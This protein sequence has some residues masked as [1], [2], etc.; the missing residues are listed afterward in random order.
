MRTYVARAFLPAAAALISAPA[1]FAQEVQESGLAAPNATIKDLK[2][3]RVAVRMADGALVVADEKLERLV[4]ADFGSGSF[5]ELIKQG[6]GDGEFGGARQIWRWTGDS[7]ALFDSTRNRVIVVS[8]SGGTPRVLTLG[9]PRGGGMRGGGAAAAGRGNAGMAG[10]GRG[11][12]GGGAGRPGG[13]NI[14]AVLEGK[15]AFVLGNPAPANVKPGSAPPRNMLPIIRIPLTPQGGAVDTVA[16]VMPAQPNKGSIRYPNNSSGSSA[17]V[18][19]TL[20]ISEFMWSDSWWVY[21]DGSVGVARGVD[22]HI[23]VF[24]PGDARS[25]FDPIPFPKVAISN[26]EK[27]RTSDD[28]KRLTQR[29][30]DRGWALVVNDGWPWPEHHPPFRHREK[31][32]VD[33]TDRVWLPVR[34]ASSA[35]VE[36]YDIINRLG[37]RV[38]RV[39]LP[40][41]TTLLAVS[42]ESVYTAFFEKSDRAVLQR[43]PLN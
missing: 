11:G 21:G 28:F 1:L 20:D 8:G 10:G 27:K 24:G 5:Q 31:S 29:T 25:N 33:D 41:K 9:V 18:K 35:E 32:F 3:P 17:H 7:V 13:L 42:G 15:Y 37:M 22:Y 12:M 16:R 40:E 34:C 36:C 6:D 19:A 43:H 2:V 14:G 39:R 38:M 26:A 4:R 30:L 23:E